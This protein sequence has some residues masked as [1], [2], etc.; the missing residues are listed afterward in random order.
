MRWRCLLT[1]LTLSL[2]FTHAQRLKSLPSSAPPGGAD[3]LPLAIARTQFELGFQK[4][5]RGGFRQGGFLTSFEDHGA[6]SNLSI[7]PDGFSL[8]WSFV[9]CNGGKKPYVR[10]Y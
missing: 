9:C 8:D 5:Y 2:C 10:N 1:M 6:L 4:M 3:K 7:T